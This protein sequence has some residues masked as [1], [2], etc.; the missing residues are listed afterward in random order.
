VDATGEQ[1]LK[2]LARLLEFTS[3]CIVAGILL[4]INVTLNGFNLQ[5]L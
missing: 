3:V 4:L 5:K 2:K 1:Q